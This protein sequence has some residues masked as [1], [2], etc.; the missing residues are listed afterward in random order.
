[1]KFKTLI[2][3]INDAYPDD[4]IAMYA[5]DLD[6]PHGDTFA[7]GIVVELSETFDSESSDE[8][9]LSTALDC[10]ETVVREIGDVRDRLQELWQKAGE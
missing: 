2:E 1:M 5:E 6:G 10:M 4:R 7:R 9:Q 3:K 8:D